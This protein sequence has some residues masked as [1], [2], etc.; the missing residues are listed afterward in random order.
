MSPRTERTI[1][2]LAPLLFLLTLLLFLQPTAAQDPVGDFCRRFGHQSAVVDNQLFIDGGL[3]NW[4]PISAFNANY[5]NGYFL[6][7]D[8]S[9]TATSGVPPLYANLSKNY[10]IPRVSGGALWSDSVNKRLYL[11]GGEQRKEVP[12]MPFS[13]YGYDILNNLW[14]K[15]G[16]SRNGDSMT[17]VSFG[18]GA[19][20]DSRGEAYYFGGWL[21]NR[22][23]S[24]WG[25]APPVATTGM[26]RYN[27]DTNSFSNITGPDKTRRAEGS[28]HYI[29]AGPG[30]MLIYFGGIQD[31]SANGTGTGQPMDQIFVFD[32]LNH[33]WY[34]QKATGEIPG[35]RG[36]FCA[37]VT[38]A[39]D[40]SSYNIYMYGGATVPDDPGPGYDDLYVLTIPTFTWVKMPTHGSNGSGKFPRH[41]LSCNMAP[42]GAQMIVIGGQFPLTQDCDSPDAWGTH[43]IDLGKQNPSKDVWDVYKPNKT[44]YIVPEEIIAVVGGSGNGGATNTIPTNGFNSTE[45]GLLITCKADI[46]IRTPIRAFNASGTPAPNTHFPTGAIVGI[47]V[48][49]A[50]LAIALG[51]G[52]FFLWRSRHQRRLHNGTSPPGPKH[53]YH[54]H[55]M[56]GASPSP[57]YGHSTLSSSPSQLAYQHSPHPMSAHALSPQM[58]SP[59]ELPSESLHSASVAGDGSSR[60]TN[61]PSTVSYPPQRAYFPETATLM[62]QPHYD[63]DGNMWMPQVSMVQLATA[64]RAPLPEYTPTGSKQETISQPAYEPQE[65]NAEP[66]KG[67][68]ESIKH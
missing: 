39:A 45:L 5:S 42:G 15:F 27:M 12:P 14:S 57:P 36:R 63:A 52:C 47:A 9:T 62:N 50:V 31:R 35:M 20:V 21:S 13:L 18:A 33:K 46:P 11:F 43:I 55:S 28:L 7:Q 37:G 67:G 44:A 10:S 61:I 22:S 58:G 4:D 30:G 29:P 3:V 66:E 16:P 38:W 54:A 65:L 25:N 19:S 23:V 59:V 49:V 64:T 53:V 56:S 48:G 68:E 34:T 2:F 8:L 24:D 40:Q 17:A 26:V 6:Y 51:M 32:A 60:L 1:P 41:S